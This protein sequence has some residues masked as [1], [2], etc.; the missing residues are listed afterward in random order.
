MGLGIFDALKSSAS[1]QLGDQWREYFYCDA[2]SNNVLMSK[3]KKR[4]S[5]NSSN[6]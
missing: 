4:T 2:L 1:G 6:T 3:G 5:K